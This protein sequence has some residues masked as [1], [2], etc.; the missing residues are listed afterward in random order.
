MSNFFADDDD[1]DDYRNAANAIEDFS[2]AGTAS[3]LDDSYS[4]AGKSGAADR[5]GSSRL[6]GAGYGGYGGGRQSSVTGGR[7]YDDS[8]RRGG[9]PSLDDILGEDLAADD[10]ERNIEKLIRAWN[11]EVG[12]PELLRFPK[13]LVER[14]AKDLVM[15][16][17]ACGL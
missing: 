8:T 1:E 15:R 12:A 13:R 6:G 5:A 16:V 7:A 9:S 4:A 11:N 17:S 3:L 14:I 10:G 2:R